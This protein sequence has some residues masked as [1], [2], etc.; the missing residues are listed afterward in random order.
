VVPALYSYLS[1]KKAVSN[2]EKAIAEE[3]T[4]VLEEVEA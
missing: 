3:N 1:S 4:K 2:F